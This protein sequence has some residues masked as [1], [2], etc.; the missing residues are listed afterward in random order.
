MNKW[1][2]LQEKCEDKSIDFFMFTYW[3]GFKI[4]INIPTEPWYNEYWKNYN[5]KIIDECLVEI[6]FRKHYEN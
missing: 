5:E 6:D 1:K 3:R 2:L 4:W